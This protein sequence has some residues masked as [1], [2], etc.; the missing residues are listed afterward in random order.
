LQHDLTNVLPSNNA[1]TNNTMPTSSA[2]S[3]QTTPLLTAANLAALQLAMEAT[4]STNTSHGGWVCGV[5]RD[6]QRAPLDPEQWN[7]LVE[8]DPLA[9]EIDSI[10]RAA[11]DAT[12]DGRN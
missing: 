10:L 3:S 12:K 7:D 9:A 5:E 11:T 6:Y 8:E 1:M 4:S 2:S